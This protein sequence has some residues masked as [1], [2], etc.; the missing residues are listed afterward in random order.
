MKKW[1]DRFDGKLLR[2]VDAIHFVMPLIYPNR[3]D[4]EAFISE[5]IDL[6]ETLAFLEKRPVFQI[7]NYKYP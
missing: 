4:N 2:D 5:T 6:T 7:E 3:C 1:G